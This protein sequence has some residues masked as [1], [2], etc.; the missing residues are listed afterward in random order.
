MRDLA[1]CLTDDAERVAHRIVEEW[2]EL[3]A[4][5]PWHR[6]PENLDQDHLP[7]IIRALVDAALLTFF[8]LEPR[9]RLV[10]VSAE[11]GEHRF[12]QGVSE[13]IISREFEL[14]RW[15]L[16]RRLKQ[17]DRIEEASQ[18]IIRID[19]ALTF[20]H[21]ASLRG[22][23]RAH[24]EQSGEWPRALEQYLEQWSFLP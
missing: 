3:G 10:H 16:W 8:E 6:V 1:R 9:R 7:D 4:R 21:G 17:E 14:L 20:A 2:H 15:A 24:I 11:H 12:R 5:E 22:F 23:H 19:S 13:E 18:A